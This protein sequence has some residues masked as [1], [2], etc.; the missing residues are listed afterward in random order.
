[1]DAILSQLDFQ[2]NVGIYFLLQFN[3]EEALYLLS[4]DFS[5][6][7]QQNPHMQAHFDWAAM[8]RIL[9]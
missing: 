5:V 8:L 2:E 7:K 6:I 1:M 3:L 9:F 4:M